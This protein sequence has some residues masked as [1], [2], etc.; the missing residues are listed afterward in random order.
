MDLNIKKIIWLNIKNNY[1]Q[2]YYYS[3][4]HILILLVSYSV[5]GQNFLTRH[6]LHTL[7]GKEITDTSKTSDI[8]K[9]IKIIYKPKIYNDTTTIR[10]GRFK[11]K[12]KLERL[13][14]STVSV[15][16]L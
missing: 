15:I 10:R 3:F 2:K 6:Y 11:G 5:Q 13:S 4:F 16:P 9:A 12:T 1:E 8:I 14:K 7:P